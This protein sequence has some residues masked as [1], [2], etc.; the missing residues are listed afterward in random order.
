[1]VY[2]LVDVFEVVSECG[3]SQ[4]RIVPD[5]EALTEWSA[6]FGLPSTEPPHRLGHI[7][8]SHQKRLSIAPEPIRFGIAK[9]AVETAGAHGG[10]GILH[11][12][13][14]RDTVPA[15]TSDL[16]LEDAQVKQLHR[17]S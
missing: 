14:R 7:G 4:R 12:S 13:R 1:L 16:S 11:I 10:V 3:W 9:S 5:F 6:L 2:P 15:L 8:S 17:L